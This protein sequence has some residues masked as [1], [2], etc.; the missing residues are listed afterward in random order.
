[1]EKTIRKIEEI[2]DDVRQDWTANDGG[3]TM[4][5]SDLLY[6]G[7]KIISKIQANDVAWIWEMDPFDTDTGPEGEII[8]LAQQWAGRKLRRQI[9]DRLRKDGRFFEQVVEIHLR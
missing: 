4:A 8:S 5:A 1:M 7:Q 9:E 6:I 2:L 3:L